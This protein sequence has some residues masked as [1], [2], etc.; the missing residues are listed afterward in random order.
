M[1][2]SF[3]S[4]ALAAGLW[5]LIV[6]VAPPAL[7]F[8]RSTSCQLGEATR[9]Q[10][11]GPACTKDEEQCVNEGQPLHWGSPCLY[12]AVQN[13]GSP[14][15]G[16]T[17]E[18]FSAAIADAFQ[19]WSQVQ[20]PG[21]GSPRFQAQLQGFVACA[22]REAVCGDESHNVSTFMLHDRLWP[23]EASA[24]GL[25]TPSGGT[26][27]GLVVDADLE[28]NSRDYRFSFGSAPGDFALRDVLAHEVGHFLGLDH[29]Q[30]A[31]ALMSE[32]YQTLALSP[33]LLTSDDI[34]GI[35]AVFPPGDALDCPAPNA[36][37]YD[38]CQVPPG[39]K[40]SCA[41]ATMTHDDSAGGCSLSGPRNPR[42]FAWLAGFL[43]LLTLAR[44]A[45]RAPRSRG[46]GLLAR[47]QP[48]AN[49]RS[50]S[51]KICRARAKPIC[52]MAARS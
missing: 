35:C 52:A 37:A 11:G 23:A 36:P 18:E 21:G 13:E 38:E 34:A 40:P 22:H 12:Y 51:S 28:L 50:T 25:T 27:S 20:C 15:Q 19:A 1:S 48:P 8:C 10:A 33:E 9:T 32:D 41:L 30:R 26:R 45:G 16:L 17:A 42:G 31:G 7:G 29:S 2:G 44:T 46:G 47:R 43:A 49:V 3:R 14:E 4:S 39:S 24:L 6:G 5:L